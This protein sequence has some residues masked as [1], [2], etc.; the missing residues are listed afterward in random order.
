MSYRYF[1]FSSDQLSIDAI[2][3]TGAP[4]PWLRSA[5]ILQRS[6]AHGRVAVIAFLA[7]SWAATATSI[8]CCS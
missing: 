6:R 3:A 1:P 2:S 8:R 5:S 4:L 7:H